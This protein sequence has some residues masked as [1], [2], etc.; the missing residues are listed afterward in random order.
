MINAVKR[1]L[2]VALA[3]HG[4]VFVGCT[5][6]TAGIEGTGAEEGDLIA[7]RGAVSKFGSVYV[8]G[9]H[10][11]TDSARFYRDGVEIAEETLKQGMV[12][13]VEG[14]RGASSDEAT[15]DEVHFDYLLQGRIERI[16]TLKSNERQ[17]HMLGHKVVLSEDAMLAIDL[18]DALKE[19]DVIAVSGLTEDESTIVATRIERIE[20]NN[21]FET[22]IGHISQYSKSEAVIK[23]NSMTV[24]IS[25]AD[26]RADREIA[27]GDLVK[28]EGFVND[29]Q[30][31]IA[32]ELRLIKSRVLKNDKGRKHTVSNEGFID[33][34]DENG[35]FTLDG[36]KVK[37]EG[38]Y[39]LGRNAFDLMKGDRVSVT[40]TFNNSGELIAKS[41]YVHARSENYL[42]GEVSDIDIKKSTITVSGVA[43]KVSKFT[44]F[45]DWGSR[46]NR[47]FGLNDIREGDLLDVFIRH[48][49]TTSYALTIRRKPE[50]PE[51]EHKLNVKG[52]IAN[53]DFDQNTLT[54][55]G[56]TVD[57]SQVDED[58]R[59]RLENGLAVFIEGS[60][61]GIH[62]F[63]ASKI[64]IVPN[65]CTSHIEIFCQWQ[66]GL[67]AEHWDDDD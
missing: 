31:M 51:F 16:S 25:G 55:A 9:I 65:G 38:A 43:F 59:A 48:E 45:E 57:L 4:L 54:I 53:V 56:I 34:I 32:N 10:F 47:Y 2:F 24:S 41:L 27:V 62:Y 13:Y 22:V 23:I 67:E 11:N 14:T 52:S 3:L 26:M 8:N 12:V 40:G 1:L 19:G 20:N 61:D 44:R 15:A 37:T 35:G 5:T 58:T 66:R 28:I 39:L 36:V 33:H 63:V 29:D 64:Y 49:T 6:R 42:S 7:A 21:P 30:I 50:Q 46:R 17:I 18:F 60:Y